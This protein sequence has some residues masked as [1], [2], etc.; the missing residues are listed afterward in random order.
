MS[1]RTLVSRNRVPGD[2]SM[3]RHLLTLVLSGLVGSLVLAG[4]AEACHKKKCTCAPAPCAVAVC[5]PA[6]CR[7]V[8][9][10]AVAVCT[11]SL[12]PAP[13]RPRFVSPPAL[14]RR[15]TVCSVASRDSGLAATRG[16][17][18]P[19]LSLLVRR[20]LTTRLRSTIQ[21]PPFTPP[22]KFRLSTEPVLS[23]LPSLII[24][25]SGHAWS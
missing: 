1:L 11:S 7:C 12:S 2:A 16:P 15:I 5:A 4:N 22:P 6:P 24:T 20:S 13:L 9:S 23:E 10:P 21:H 14:P 8:P 19:S 3:K 25:C 18:A 17:F